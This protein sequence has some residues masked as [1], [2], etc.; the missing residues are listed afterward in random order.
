MIRNDYSNNFLKIALFLFLKYNIV[1]LFY[2]ESA[3]E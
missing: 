3:I 2:W 1:E